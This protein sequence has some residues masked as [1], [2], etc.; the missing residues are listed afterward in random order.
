MSSLRYFLF[1]SAFA[2]SA[3][4]FFNS[5]Q[6]AQIENEPRLPLDELRHFTQVFDQIRQAYVEEMDDEKLLEMSIKGLL[7]SLDPHSVYLDKNSFSSL[8]EH[9]SGEFG[10]LGIEIGMEG[11]FIKVIS[12]IDDT[13][14]QRAGILAGDI[15]IKLG[16]QAVQSLSLGE[17][18]EIMRGPKG[19]PLTL[20]I[21]REQV[22]SPFEIVVTRD[23]IKIHSVRSK[24]LEP[25]FGYIRVA[26]FQENTG[27]Q[28]KQALDTLLEEDD[29][30]KGIVIDLRNNPG[31]LLHAS[32]EV[33]DAILD[34]GMVVYTEGRLP[35]ANSTYYANTGDMLKGL[36]IV[37]LINEGSAS[38]A[39]IVAG[40]LQ[41][42]RRAILLGTNSFGKGSVQ[43]VIPL[44]E[45][46]GIKLT[47]ARY[48]TPNKRS[49][50]AEGIKPDIIVE[51]AEIK[52]LKRQNNI[53]EAN[54]SGHLSN[55]TEHQATTPNKNIAM[56]DNQLH[57]ALN[58]LKGLNLL[59]Q[60][61]KQDT[62]HSKKEN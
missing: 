4:V 39:E 12:P 31:G 41:D 61:K 48:F 42:H 3:I 8:Q 47:T 36:P 62:D 11:A 6:A 51:P 60:N 18:I 50:Q 21:V 40:A 19:S 10:G 56:D 20:T 2:F 58:L 22:D 1:S 24:T 52:I 16:E 17:A 25:G 26:Q 33:T 27:Q 7:S 23:I 37:V 13:P 14:A 45:D 43:T 57:D 53:K 30:L 9:T 34:G 38:A 35:S 15:I 29:G 44:G 49:I 5:S 28:F 32:I 55:N 46:R 59:N 54:L